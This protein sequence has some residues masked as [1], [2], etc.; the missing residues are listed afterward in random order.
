MGLHGEICNT[1]A[2]KVVFT[3]PACKNKNKTA[4]KQTSLVRPSQ[5]PQELQY[6]CSC[7]CNNSSKRIV[8]AGL[9]VG[10]S[11]KPLDFQGFCFSRCT[12]ISKRDIFAGLSVGSSQTPEELRIL[13][14][15]GERRYLPPS[16]SWKPM[17][18][19][20]IFTTKLHIGNFLVSWGLFRFC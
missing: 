13:E 12:N 3:P 17:S 9:R 11:P 5:K 4:R 6:F 20:H 7:R 1:S 15:A 2:A 16:M 19:I 18:E 8:F 10:S 14:Y